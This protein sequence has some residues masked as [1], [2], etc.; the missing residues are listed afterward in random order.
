VVFFDAN[1]EMNVLKRDHEPDD[2]T[3]PDE[4]FERI[5]AAFRRAVD[6]RAGIAG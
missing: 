2:V 4:P 1:A 6:R 5:K 3:M